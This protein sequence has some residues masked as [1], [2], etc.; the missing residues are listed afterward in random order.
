MKFDAFALAIVAGLV[1]FVPGVAETPTEAYDCAVLQS[2]IVG[3]PCRDDDGTIVELA[4]S[5]FTH[6]EITYGGIGPYPLVLDAEL[7][8]GAWQMGDIV[9]IFRLTG[10]GSATITVTPVFGEF[11]RTQV[12]YLHCSPQ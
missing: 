8:H 3:Q 10:D 5:D 1:P 9:L 11:D 7:R 12:Q 2:C 6:A 4:F